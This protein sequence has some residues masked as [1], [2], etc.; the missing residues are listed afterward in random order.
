MVL[1]LTHVET[2]E[3]SFID[4]EISN[5]VNICENFGR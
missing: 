3:K 4:R 2:G 1:R 5:F